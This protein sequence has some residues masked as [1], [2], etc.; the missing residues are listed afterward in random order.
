MRGWQKL[1]WRA[2]GASTGPLP[3]SPPIL[4]AALHLTH[5][6]S[7]RAG[8]LPA[9]LRGLQPG[10]PGHRHLQGLWARQ[11]APSSMPPPTAVHPAAAGAAPTSPPCHRL[12]PLPPRYTPRYTSSLPRPPQAGHPA[13]PGLPAEAGQPGAGR[14]EAR[15][16]PQRGCSGAWC[17]STASE[18]GRAHS[19]PRAK[20][21]PLG[22][23]A[24][25]TAWWSAPRRAPS[26]S[27]STRTAPRV[28]AGAGVGSLWVLPLRGAESGRCVPAV[29]RCWLLWVLG[30]PCSCCSSGTLPT[31]PQAAALHP[32]PAPTPH[33][34]RLPAAE[35]GERGGVGGAGRRGAAQVAA[36]GERSACGCRLLGGA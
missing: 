8:P 12:Q 22:R 28:G 14:G 33:R 15:G 24:S 20:R 16:R 31:G 17:L 11:G 19:A 1:Q 32:S 34:G 25:A 9:Q 36:G 27:P 2:A 35:P 4:P 5:P 3:A 13:L 18:A 6:S 7:P 21:L 26:R 23:W 10:G 30:A 29:W